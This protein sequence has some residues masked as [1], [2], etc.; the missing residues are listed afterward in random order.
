MLRLVFGEKTYNS[1]IYSRINTFSGTTVVK[2][3]HRY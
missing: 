2:S 1:Y 3:E